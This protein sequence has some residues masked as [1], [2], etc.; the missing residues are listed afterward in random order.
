MD[1]DLRRPPLEPPRGFDLYNSGWKGGPKMGVLL[2]WSTMRFSPASGGG[3]LSCM[4]RALWRQRGGRPPKGLRTRFAYCAQSQREVS[5][6]DWNMVA[7]AHSLS[8]S[9]G[10]TVLT[11]AALPLWFT[12]TSYQP[13]P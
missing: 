9:A 6:A 10:R 8:R 2:A 12:R 1:A 3:G 13:G 5:Q 7:L 11:G 4:R